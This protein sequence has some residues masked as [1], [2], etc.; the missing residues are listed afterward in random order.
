MARFRHAL[1][2]ALALLA[3]PLG[4]ALGS[5]HTGRISDAAA[6]RANRT[7]VAA[8]EAWHAA[9]GTYAGATLTG[10]A[11]LRPS[12]RDVP[13]LALTHVSAAGYRITTHATTGRSFR[14]TRHPATGRTFFA[15]SPAGRGACR[16][17]GTWRG[18]R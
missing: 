4:V 1:A 16:A 18:H 10:L 9:H 2:T 11:A 13:G 14:A 15:C 6:Q 3:L 7:A 12:L 5:G 8:L 17:G